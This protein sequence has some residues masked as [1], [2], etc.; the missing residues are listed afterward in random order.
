MGSRGETKSPLV[1][2]GAAQ[3][4]SRSNRDEVGRSGEP[5]GSWGELG[6]F[7]QVVM[8]R[9]DGAAWFGAGGEAR[10]QVL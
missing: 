9:P 1:R 10:L 8:Q 2:V 5:W 3:A 6:G 7:P 4:R